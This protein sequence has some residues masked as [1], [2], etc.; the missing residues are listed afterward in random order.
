MMAKNV[1]YLLYRKLIT[2]LHLRFQF[3]LLRIL[4]CMMK[5][6]EETL[7]GLKC[8]QFLKMTIKFMEFE[9]TQL[10]NL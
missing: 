10:H 5:V 7:L 8:H 2:K 6:R 4:R 1:I 9:S 3:C